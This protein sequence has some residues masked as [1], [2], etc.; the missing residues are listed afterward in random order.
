[1]NP[2][3][4]DLSIGKVISIFVLAFLTSCIYEPFGVYENPVNINPDAPQIANLELN[5]NADTL[6]VYGNQ[7]LKY[8][9]ESSNENQAI[10]GLKIYI[11]GVM[12]DS[13][14][15]DNGEFDILESALSEGQ[16]K[17]YIYLFVKSGTGSI[18]DKLNGE[19]MLLRK[20]WVVIA[21]YSKKDITYTIE[22]GFLKLHWEKYKNPDLKC[23][24]IQYS[25]QTKNNYFTDSLYYGAQRTFNI[26][27]EKTNGDI[28]TWGS[29]VM[30][31]NIAKPELK[32]SPN[33]TYY[34][35]WHKSPYYNS[36]KYRYEFHNT[37]DGSPSYGDYGYKKGDDTV[38]LC[39]LHFSERFYITL[40][41]VPKNLTEQTNDYMIYPSGYLSQYAG[42]PI[43][44]RTNT[45]YTSADTLTAF[46]TKNVYKYF[47]SGETVYDE[48]IIQGSSFG[49]GHLQI[50]ARGKFLLGKYY[51]SSGSGMR[52]FAK[53]LNSGKVSQM[54]FVDP[55]YNVV[56]NRYDLNISDN[57]IGIF[58]LS[59]KVFLYDF[60]NNTEIASKTFASATDNG[61]S[62]KISPDGKHY[63][64]LISSQPMLLDVYK[65][66][67]ASLEKMYS[68]ES[69]TTKYQFNPIDPN[70]ITAIK[71]K[72]LSVIQCEPY[73]L[74][75][76]I[77]FASDE[78][79]MNIDYFN[80]EVLSI[81]ANQ[82]I[83]R[84][85]ITGNEI[86]RITKGRLQYYLYENFI[87]HN[88]YIIKNN[89][90]FNTL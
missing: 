15:S 17:M 9:F 75:R 85:L 32:I 70:M 23:Y 8:H 60:I 51:D 20:E 13:V 50:S 22:N 77:E 35:T 82:F 55:N 52:Y 28:I 59:T 81:N 72:T 7:K 3:K 41:T 64:A 18:V 73:A 87:L 12:R 6:W 43:N 34:I 47:V 14:M 2:V 31:Q 37:D 19:T 27:V 5:V 62:F 40:T 11:D 63:I 10:L 44:I 42:E 30:D 56:D 84:S 4:L 67:G 79:F 58:K 88:H 57:G 38:Y 66:N 74:L 76:K 68:L 45:S 36:I 39:K 83:I 90:M 80:N 78:V 16:H 65:I 46:Y 89:V 54:N 21:D 48:P 86:K 69:G 49:T 1:M 24:K 26:T 29:L 71:D 33:N 61:A 25:G 53:N